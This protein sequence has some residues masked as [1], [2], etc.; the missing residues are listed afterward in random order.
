M[1]KISNLFVLILVFVLASCGGK[2]PSQLA[3]RSALIA[4]L[5]N[6][7]K[8]LPKPMPEFKGILNDINIVNDTIIYVAEIPTIEELP[9]AILIKNKMD[10]DR[11]AATYITRVSNDVT[12][13]LLD[14]GFGIKYRLYYNHGSDFFEYG[15]DYNQLKRVSEQLEK[16]DIEPY[17]ELDITSLQ[18]ADTEFPQDLGDGTW[19]TAGYV[20]GN[21]ICYVVSTELEVEPSLITY[22][23][24]QEMKNEAILVLKEGQD[25]DYILKTMEK[26]NIQFVYIYKD[27]NDVEWARFSIGAE[28]L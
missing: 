10:A 19:L 11:V 14:A 20:E 13:P 22:E 1:K 15:F 23:D 12:E 21:S 6:F 26:E 28:D 8:T 17:S 18:M 2:T 4:D 5:E 27:C 3:K 9:Y 16:G 25:F 24:I 7:K